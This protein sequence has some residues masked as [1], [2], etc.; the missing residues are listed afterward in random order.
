MFY[1]FIL[2]DVGRG[3]GII[4][5]EG[6]GGWRAEVWFGWYGSGVEALILLG[7]RGLIAFWFLLLENFSNFGK[8]PLLFA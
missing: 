8:Y 6:G 4:R 7:G 2:Y 1:I 3:V 5:V